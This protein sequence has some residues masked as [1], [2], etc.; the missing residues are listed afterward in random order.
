MQPFKNAIRMCN[1]NEQLPGMYP[2][3]QD[4]D[5]LYSMLNMKYFYFYF[6]LY[7]YIYMSKLRD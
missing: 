4:V 2:R 3:C 6:I 7:I 5:Q 1:Y